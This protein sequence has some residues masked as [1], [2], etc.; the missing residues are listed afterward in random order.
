MQIDFHHGVTYVVARSAGFNH[1]EAS[2]IAH[3]AQYVDDSTNAGTI[4]FDNGIQFT[5]ISAAH[6]LFDYRNFRQ[7]ANYQVWI[8][9][10]FPPGNDSLPAGQSPAGSPINSLICRP[11]SYVARSMVRECIRQRHAPCS[12][13]RLGI[14]MHVY[15]DT[16]SHQGFVGV[17]H[18]V[19]QARFILDGKGNPDREFNQ[20]VRKY[21]NKN[22]L[23]RLANLFISEA[24]P[25]GHG[26]VLSK[27][28]KPFLKWGYINGLGE[29][30]ERDNPR[31]F[32]EAADQMCRW[33]RRYRTGDPDAVV[34]GL[35]QPD[36]DTIDRLIRTITDKDSELR[37]QQW[38][39][40]IR[41]GKF[42]FGEATVTYV[43]KGKG[44]WKHQALG[45][46]KEKDTGKEIFPYHPAFLNS[47]WKH[48]HDAL[49]IHR[50]Y[51]VKDLLPQ[52]GIVV[53]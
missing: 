5:R 11:N 51:V 26:A 41:A 28:D 6:K 33:M 24:L 20:R 7:L 15:A 16:W 1:R 30:I 25:L 9:F 14:T 13:Y 3:S 31:D 47:H 42:S 23:E 38:L 17:N 50:D 4:Q 40:A 29:R 21:F 52:Y 36:K 35:P 22:W 48:F 34:C 32:L 39:T 19:N 37:Q 2:I 49:Q 10:H 44:S 53:A 43:A 8:P 27:P 18:R 45:T 46:E 12:L